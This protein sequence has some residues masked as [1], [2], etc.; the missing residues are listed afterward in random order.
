MKSYRIKL[1][2]NSPLHIGIKDEEIY[3]IKELY[4]SHLTNADLIEKMRDFVDTDSII[5]A[6]SAEPARIEELNRAGFW[7]KPAYKSVKDGIDFVKRHRVHIH[8]ECVN[9]I[10][11]IEMYS[12]KTDKEGNILEEPVKFKDHSLDALRY[13]MTIYFEN[14]EIKGYKLDI[15]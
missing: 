8:K 10:E 1:K 2:F 15:L 9:T 7:V 12:W 13:A 6:D 4:E 3:V 5:Y 11:E 14:T